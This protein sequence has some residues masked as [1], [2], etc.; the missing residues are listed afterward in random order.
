MYGQLRSFN[1]A[2]CSEWQERVLKLALTLYGSFQGTLVGFNP[3][4]P[5]A[6]FLYHWK[7]QKTVMLTGDRKRVHWEPMG[8]I[9]TSVVLWEVEMIKI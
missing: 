7:H 2:F 5:N 6:P 4:V 9:R 3:F 1:S 8:K